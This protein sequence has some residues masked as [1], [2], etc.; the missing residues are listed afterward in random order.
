MDYELLNT[1]GINTKTGIARFAGKEVL[2]NKYLMKFPEDPTFG[3][4]KEQMQKGDYH[5]AF[6]SAHSLK[7]ISGNLSLDEF[8]ALL[9]QLV[10]CLRNDTDLQGAQEIF[11]NLEKLYNRTVET[12]H[13]ES[14]K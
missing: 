6:R 3:S 4:L 7:G 14:E 2:Y 11:P 5:E 1:V 8:L 10:E 12:I 13:K 9:S